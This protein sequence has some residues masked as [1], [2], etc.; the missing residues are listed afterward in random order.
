[1]V[2]E[3]ILIS[4]TP[5]A[6]RAFAITIPNLFLSLFT[7]V[8][9]IPSFVTFMFNETGSS[10]SEK[11]SSILV[12]IVTLAANLVT[13]NIIERFNRRTLY[14][15]SSICT[16]LSYL[17]FAVYGFF[18]KGQPG[19]EWLDW[20]P[21]FCFGSI[22]FC[23]WLGIVPI[24]YLLNIEL[25]P[26]KIR[27]TCIALVISII[28]TVLFVYGIIFYSIVELFGLYMCMVILGLFS[29]LTALFAIFFVPETRGKSYEEIRDL[30]IK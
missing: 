19:L 26:K 20:M 22:V 8:L 3:K 6:K 21:L 16:M 24:P 23:S 18:L 12:S 10:L 1:M 27:Q 28:W 30:L 15:W 7:G 4:G 9:S 2:S 17:L 29:F 5:H 25:A 13:L 11:N 14:I